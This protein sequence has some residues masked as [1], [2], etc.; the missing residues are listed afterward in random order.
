MFK[1]LGLGIF[2]F[3]SALPLLHS[4]NIAT[5]LYPCK[6][7]EINWKRIEELKLTL[8]L[9]VLSKFFDGVRHNRRTTDEVS[10]LIV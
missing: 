7:L 2:S 3:P 6:Y 5:Y 1:E 9:K 8:R 4:M 10:L